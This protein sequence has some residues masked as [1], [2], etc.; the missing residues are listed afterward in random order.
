M[1]V[2]KRKMLVVDDAHIDR[3]ILK[4]I[5]KDAYDVLEARD[6][7]EA[8]ALIKE[9]NGELSVVL[10]DLLIPSMNGFELLKK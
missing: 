3:Q 7:N 4:N 5:F 6:G 8:L 2:L 9:W 10:L 1:S